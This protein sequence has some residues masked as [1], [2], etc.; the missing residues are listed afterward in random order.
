MPRT[1]HAAPGPTTPDDLAEPTAG[2][3]AG[4]EDRLAHLIRTVYRD[5]RKSLQLRLA[6]QGIPIGHWSILRILWAED[7]LTQKQLA[8]QVGI[9]E[10]TTVKSLKMMEKLD[11]VRRDRSTSDRRKVHVFLTERSRRL[12]SVLVP[13]AEEVNKIALKGIEPVELVLLRRLLNV[14]EINLQSDHDALGAK[15]AAARRRARP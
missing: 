5:L 1:R 15:S 6:E 13:M 7:G 4:F 12:E 9:M 3:I 2:T 11:L 10:P 8:D 14:I